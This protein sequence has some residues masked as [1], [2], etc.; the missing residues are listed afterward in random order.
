MSR[1]ESL[2]R[3]LR[4]LQSGLADVEASALV[5]EDGLVIASALQQGIE[6]TRVAA[7]SAA[8]LA[9][10]GRSAQELRR[11]KLEQVYVKGDDGYAILMSAGPHAVLLALARKESKLGLIFFELQRASEELKAILS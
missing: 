5:S 6:E 11:G 8:M 3:A 1:T 7:M 9:M 2:N 4:A 10:A